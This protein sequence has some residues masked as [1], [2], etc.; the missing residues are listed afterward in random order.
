MNKKEN[1]YAQWL[2]KF[3]CMRKNIHAHGCIV[4]IISL[5]SAYALHAFAFLWPTLNSTV[6]ACLPCHFCVQMKVYREIVYICQ[7]QL[8]QRQT[9]TMLCITVRHLLL[10]PYHPGVSWLMKQWLLLFG[11]CQIRAS[12]EIHVHKKFIKRKHCY[13]ST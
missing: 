5:R 12:K 3:K 11:C 9:I 10:L 2:C 7:K 6:R 4:C 1:I 13:N 8:S